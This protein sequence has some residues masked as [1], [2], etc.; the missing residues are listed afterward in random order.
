MKKA[1]FEDITDLIS[2]LGKFPSRDEYLKVGKFKREVVDEAFTSYT[3][4]KAAY[5]LQKHGLVNIDADNVGEV[6]NSGNTKLSREETDTSL[7]IVSSSYKI[8]TVEEL[9]I[10]SNV[11]VEEFDVTKTVVNSWGSISN[12]C[13]QVKAFLTKKTPDKINRKEL[14]KEFRDEAVKYAPSYSKLRK[15]KIPVLK[16][17]KD[18][19]Y[20]VS[21]QDLHFGSL[22]WA[23]ETGYDNYDIK[24]AEG[25]MLDAVDAFIQNAKGYNIDEILFPIGSDFFNVNNSL[26]TTVKGTPQDEDCRWQK[27]FHKGVLLLVGCID[28][29]QAAFD[30]EVKVPVVYGNHDHE[31]AYYAGEVLEAWYNNN[32]KVIVDNTPVMR[33]Y[34]Q[35]HNNLVGLTHGHEIKSDRLPLL[36]ATESGNMWTDTKFREWHIGHLHHKNSKVYNSDTE[37]NGIRIKIIPSMVAIDAWHAKKGF[38]SIRECQSFLWHK[39]EGNKVQFNYSI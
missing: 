15:I 36:M 7:N 29:L 35:Y 27:S 13:Y 24:I 31:R 5:N 38:N 23:E 2:R 1:I 39:E 30:C 25:L 12:T 26:N 33:K 32:S 4:M 3:K 16:G 21:I 20:E 18:F 10:Y 37:E 17:V 14:L 34:I 6:T 28:K 8:K 19:M 9:L 22:A 11:D